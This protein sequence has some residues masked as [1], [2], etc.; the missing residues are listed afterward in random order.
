MVPMYFLSLWCILWRCGDLSDFR[1]PLLIDAY[2]C[3]AKR[4][5]LNFYLLYKIKLILFFWFACNVNFQQ[6]QR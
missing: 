4:S 6:E 5:H 3:R 1:I 2:L